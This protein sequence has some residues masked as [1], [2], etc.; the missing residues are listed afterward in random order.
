MATEERKRKLI[1]AV[2]VYLKKRVRTGEELP[3]VE[4][5]MHAEEEEEEEGKEGD[6]AATVAEHMVM[7]GQVP[8]EVFVELMEMMAVKW[9]MRGGGYERKRKGK[10][11]V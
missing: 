5:M 3:Q 1:A 10:R 2:P 4:V 8:T 6:I 7:D 11:R 9:M